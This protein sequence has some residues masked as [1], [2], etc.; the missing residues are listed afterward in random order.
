MDGLI[1]DGIN[2]YLCEAGNSNE[3]VEILKKIE[4][5]TPEKKKQ[6]S[7]NA[8]ATARFYTDKLAADRYINSVLQ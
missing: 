4:L 5:M 3:L 1:E 8:V 7:D 2:G 6:L